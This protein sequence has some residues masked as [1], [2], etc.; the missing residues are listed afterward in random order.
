VG[1]MDLSSFAKFDVTGPDAAAFLDRILANRLP[2]KVG[3]IALAH[4]LTEN[5]MIET[6]FTVTKLA[7][8]RFY[9]SSSI[10]AEMRD[11][12]HLNSLKRAD[13]AV[14]VENVTEQ[15]GVLVVAGPKS[16]DLLK[17]L[18]QTDLS[19]TNFRWLTAQEIS[20]AGVPVR[21]LRV[22]YVGEL[23]WELHAPCDRMAELYEKVWQTGLA[24]G[25]ANVGLYAVNSM[26]MEKAYR[27]WG[28]ELTNEITLIEADM[29]RFLAPDKGDFRGRAATLKRKADGIV[30][31]LVYMQIDTTDTSPRGGEPVYSD[32][33]VA[34]VLTSGGYGHTVRTG[35][36]FGYVKPELASPG[37]RLE[38]ELL[39]DLRL[40]TVL[41]DPILDPASERPRA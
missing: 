29:E 23:G 12:D 15:R 38:V 11:W 33:K 14:A 1:I 32:G 5:G 31:R 16:R 35:L 2:K 9:L 6:E 25:V 40:A 10:A 28:G 18:T 8:D 17:G 19:N 26:R 22:N 13:E 27:G 21:A 39:G 41:A 7:E 30:T 24:H 4:L 20:V 37:T 36:A 3:G 34:G